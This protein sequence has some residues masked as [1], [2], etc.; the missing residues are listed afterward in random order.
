MNLPPPGRVP[1]AGLELAW[2]QWSADAPGLPIVAL[3]G[4]TGSSADWHRTA[5]HLDR[6]V[7]AFDARGHGGSAW[8]PDEDYSVD[9]HFAD[10]RTA[11]DHLGIERC[12]LAGFS[13][14][15]TVAILT[16][17]CVPERIAGL[18]VIDSYP[19]PAQSPGS[20]RIARWVGTKAHVSRQFDPAIARHFRELL[21]A[22]I[23]TRADLT[24]MW[25]AISCPTLIVRGEQS[26]VL[27]E[28]TASAMLRD[29]PHARL[30]TVAGIGHGIPHE[31]PAALAAILAAFAAE[32]D[33]EP[34]AEN[35]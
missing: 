14:G 32:V 11:L 10:L 6:R 19:Y 29:L 18:A 2:R 15:G 25:A 28:P 34:R 1:G 5:A 30:E 22:G 35:R 3:H 12:V 9:A 31:R 17:A 23:S 26:A 4:I 8:D 7:I 20:S 16:S 21:E 13:M 33:P 27:P 24:S